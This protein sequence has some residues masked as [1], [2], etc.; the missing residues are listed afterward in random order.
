MHYSP[1]GF[2]VHGILQA[3]ILKWV[4]ISFSRVS[5]RPRDQIQ[6][7]CITGRFFTVWATRKVLKS[8]QKYV[9]KTTSKR[10]WV[11]PDAQWL[12]KVLIYWFRAGSDM[13][14]KYKGLVTSMPKKQKIYDFFLWKLTRIFNRYCLWIWRLWVSFKNPFLLIFY[15]WVVYLIN[16]YHLYNRK[17]IF[18]FKRPG[19]WI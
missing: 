3:R 18:N 13:K 7:S 14:E 15:I 6:V 16:V 9:L 8:E 12:D 4:A 5:S 10:W 1:P 19:K 2:S 11:G 17:Y